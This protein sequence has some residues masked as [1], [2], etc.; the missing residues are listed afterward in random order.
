MRTNP[1]RFHG[2]SNPSHLPADESFSLWLV[3]AAVFLTLVDPTLGA[4]AGMLL[5]LLAIIPRVS[6]LRPLPGTRT[7]LLLVSW[8]ILSLTWTRSIDL[9]LAAIRDMVVAL[10][11]VVAVGTVCTSSRRVT[12][13]ATSFF[14]GLVIFIARFVL[15]NGLTPSALLSGASTR[16]TITGINANQVAYTLATGVAVTLALTHGGSR[17]RKF[18]WIVFAVTA[19]I[20]TGMTGSRGAVLGLILLAAWVMLHRL[21]GGRFRSLLATAF[22]LLPAAALSGI[23]DDMF[24]P[25]TSS[26]RDTGDLNGR[27]TIWPIARAMTGEN[28]MLGVGFGAFEEVAGFGI[29]THNAYL[30]YAS[31]T[32][33]IGLLLFCLVLYRLNIRGGTDRRA[34]P[35]LSGAVAIVSAPLLYTGAWDRSAVIWIALALTA[36]SFRSGISDGEGETAETLLVGGLDPAE[37]FEKS[38]RRGR[39]GMSR[40]SYIQANQTHLPTDRRIG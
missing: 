37:S 19:A 6:N 9:T 16:A 33:L 11:L 23:L 3:T 18:S 34:V 21:A 29:R 30:A 15:Q 4:T 39:L 1:N 38:H 31:E 13:V 24:R 14:A 17:L 8:V 7:L 28:P 20:A 26:V 5:A 12:T 32:G 27:L 40:P 35:L 2:R 22:W 36:S 10:I 25:A